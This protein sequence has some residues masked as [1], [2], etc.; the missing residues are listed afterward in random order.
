MKRRDFLEST[1]VGATA[2]ALESGAEPLI[3]ATGAADPIDRSN[4]NHRLAFDLKTAQLVSLRSTAAPEQ[5][6]IESR[7]PQPAFVIQYLDDKKA[8]HEISSTQAAHTSISTAGSTLRAEFLKVGGLD[9]DA[10]IT[11]K[12]SGTEPESR[13]SIAVH[14]RAGLAITDVQ[15]PF[16]IVRYQLGGKPKTEAIL[17]PFSVGRL[18]RAPRPIEMQ[19]DSGP[20]WQFQPENGD[21]SHYPGLTFAQ[22]LAYYN[23]RAGVYI[24]CEDT[25]GAVKLIKPVHRGKGIRLGF[26]HAGDWPSQGS[27]KLEYDVVVRTFQ[28]D[29]YDAA[30][31]YRNWSLKQHWAQEPLHTRKT[32]PQ[33]LLDSPAHIVFR[34]QGEI[35]KGPAE[36]NTQ[37][38]PYPK[39][40]P[41]AQRASKRLNA[42]VAPII[43]SWERPGPWIYPD[44]FPPAGG[45]ASLKQFTREARQHG[46]HVGTYCNGTRWVIEQFWS[47]YDGRKYFQEHNG[48]ASVCRT[49]Q[50]E[51]WMETWDRSWRPSYAC[52]A[53]AEPT[54]QIAKH[55]FQHLLND[56]LDWIQFLD[57]NVGCSTFPCFSAA[58]GHAPAPGKWM[59]A[60]MDQLLKVLRSES[61]AAGRPIAFSVENAPNEYFMGRFDIC[62]VRVNPPGFDR[63]P[64]WVPLWNYLFHEFTLIQG[65]FGSAPNP[66]S[67]SIRNAY[68]LTTGAIPGAVIKG[69]GQILNREAEPWALWQPP[70]GNLEGA[71]EV[72]RTT[73]ALRRGKAR[74]FLVYGRMERPA[75]IEGIPVKRWTY[76]DREYRIPAVFHSAWHSPS[77]GFGIVLANW[78]S[79]PHTVQVRDQR[80]GARCVETVSAQKMESQRHGSGNDVAVTLPAF[81]CALVERAS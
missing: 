51:R 8:F 31:L 13:W 66:Y 42:P 37:F 21:T 69:D 81:S 52:C 64:H 11:V 38:V 53:A 55:F 18:H 71:W 46:W 70:V 34:I 77:G 54:R 33:W 30:E 59:T 4:A 45:D 14:N 68:N 16:V 80:L 56:G 39:I 28:G 47:N 58:H 19:P 61:D 73:T 43:M 60:A 32:V 7:V 1:L 17:Q 49:A 74:D 62:D 48:D 15:F 50:G 79:D 20:A 63:V 78:T 9:L 24:A 10:E 2:V 65:T 27:R 72:F 36:L 40:V 29:W 26:A 23:D 25:S 22:F 5:E 35:D 44:C 76:A 41:L 12:T 3:A 67:A 6:F 57:Q 75:K